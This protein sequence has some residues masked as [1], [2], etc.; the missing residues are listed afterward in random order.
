AA[1]GDCPKGGFVGWSARNLLANPDDGWFWN[2]W[3][4]QSQRFF[5]SGSP[6]VDVHDHAPDQIHHDHEDDD[7]TEHR[8][9]GITRG[10]RDDDGRKLFYRLECDSPYRSALETRFQRHLGARQHHDHP[11]HV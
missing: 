4:F 3:F 10:R 9:R 8:T 2:R 5:S 7:W 6:R 1:C 11:P